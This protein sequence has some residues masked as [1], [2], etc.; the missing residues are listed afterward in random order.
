MYSKANFF[1]FIFFISFYCIEKQNTLIIGHRGAKGHIAENTI[2][3]LKYAIDL[4]V[5]GIE[6][7]VFRCKSGEIV[8]FHE[9]LSTGYSKINSNSLIAKGFICKKFVFKFNKR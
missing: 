1:I 5:N 4:G 8:V 2:P 3:S 9:D 6:I 7:D